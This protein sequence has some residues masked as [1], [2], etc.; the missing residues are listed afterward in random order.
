LGLRYRQS[1]DVVT[2]QIVGETLLVPIRGDLAG[3]QRLF[4]LDAVGEFIWQQLNDATDLAAICEAVV[5]RFDVGL[6]CAEE[7]VRQFISE[8]QQAGLVREAI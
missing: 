8:L 1:K 3:S 5:E 2:R 7:D 4:A 6:Q